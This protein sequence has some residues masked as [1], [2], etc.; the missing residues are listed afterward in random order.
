MWPAGL[1]EVKTQGIQATVEYVFTG[2]N[3][4]TK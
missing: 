4:T 1:H 2:L 3:G